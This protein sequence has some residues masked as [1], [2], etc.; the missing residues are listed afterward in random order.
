MTLATSV[1]AAA[2]VATASKSQTI[3]DLIVPPAAPP[4]IAERT[5]KGMVES[6]NGSTHIFSK[7]M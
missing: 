4:T 2:T 7:A 5:A 3:N 1:D 6:K